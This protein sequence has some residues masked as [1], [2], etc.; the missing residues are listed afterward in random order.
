M[1]TTQRGK[2]GEVRDAI[3]AFL[4]ARKGQDATVPEVYA[5][6]DKACGREVP[7]SSIRSYLQYGQGIDRSKRGVYRWTGT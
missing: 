5:A 2:P 7:R 6:V 4:Q 3:L 1:A